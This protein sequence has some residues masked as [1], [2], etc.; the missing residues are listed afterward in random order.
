MIYQVQFRIEAERDIENAA[1]WYEA[2]SQG[3]GHNYLNQITE[4]VVKLKE[5]PFLY[6]VVHKG[7]RRVLIK[8]FPFGIYFRG[9]G[10]VAK[11]G[12][13]IAISSPL[14]KYG[15]VAVGLYINMY[16]VQKSPVWYLRLCRY[17]SFC[18]R[19]NHGI[20]LCFNI[21]VNINIYFRNRKAN[22]ESITSF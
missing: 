1:R 7:I 4:A 13:L 11:K 16:Y 12:Y 10:H 2:Q 9:R 18:F 3:L 22:G 6:P 19:L 17:S 5:S 15:F 8:K 20:N 14:L 21:R